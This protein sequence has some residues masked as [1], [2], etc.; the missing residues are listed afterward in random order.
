[1]PLR[2]VLDLK[3][4]DRFSLAA[5]PGA[6]V[7][8]RCGDVELFQAQLGRRENRLAVR[9]EKARPLPVLPSGEEAA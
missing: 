6:P 2:Q 8:L 9:I 1:M 5:G 7:S 3:V 4:G